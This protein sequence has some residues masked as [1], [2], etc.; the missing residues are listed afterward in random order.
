MDGR[1]IGHALLAIGDGT[2]HQGS[3]RIEDGLIERLDDGPHHLDYELPYGSTVTPGLIDLHV[4]G[5]AGHWFN[6]QPLD[7]MRRL[8]T[9]G[10]RGGLTAYLPTIITGPWDQMIRAASEVYRNMELP[11]DGARALGVHFEGPFLSPEY[12]RF[13][14]LEHLIA[15]TPARIEALL[16]TW[17]SGRCRVT[18]APEMPEAARAAAELRRRGVILSA[19][20][21]AATFAEGLEAIE[22]G[23]R[24]LTHSF[25]A[26]PGLHHRASSILVAYMLDPASF[27]EV[28]ADGAH[29]SPE[30]VALLYRLKGLNL[31]LATDAMPLTEGLVEDGGVVRDLDGVIAGSNLR[32]DDA[33]RN[34]MRAT[35]V[36]LAEAIASATWAPARAIG[37]DSEIGMLREGLRADLAVWDRHNRISHVFVGGKLV[38]TND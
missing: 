12:R 33:V 8:S 29:V 14:A 34:L 1:T 23:Y 16:G 38:Y 3:I 9:S 26:M 22:A 36:S 13:H 17:T 37:L 32:P 18:M 21:T 20:H 28:I 31:V 27:C 10:L 30:H 24:I 7:A 4:N 2:S 19:G 35:G 5:A 11:S 15:P 6:R 25:N